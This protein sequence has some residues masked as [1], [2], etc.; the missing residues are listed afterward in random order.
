MASET[1]PQTAQNQTPFIKPTGKGQQFDA[2]VGVFAERVIRDGSSAIFAVTVALGDRLGIYQAMA[3]SGP[4]SVKQI[5]DR[6]HLAE[7]HVREWLAAQ[8]AAE[9]LHYDP[10]GATYTL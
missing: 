1:N 5:A 7:R 2:K 4:L 6:C 9:Y 8:V 10:R 3:G